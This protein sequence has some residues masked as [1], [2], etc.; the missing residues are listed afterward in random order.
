MTSP[1]RTGKER[2][3]MR[4]SRASRARTTAVLAAGVTL[5]ACADTREPA[6]LILTGGKIATVDES[7]SIAETIV[8]KDGR[9]LAVGGND[10]ADQYLANTTVDLEGRLVVPGFNDT[11][12]H[13]RGN[14]RRHIDLGGT[15][16]IQE[17]QS[18]VREKVAEIGEGE[19]ITGYGWSEDELAEGRRPLRDDLDEAAPNSPVILT[20]AGGH[21]GVANSLALSLAEVDELTPQPDGGVIERDA[22]GRLNGVIRERQGIVSR[23]VPDATP[24]E[25]RETQVQMLRDQLALGITS[26]IQAGESPAGFARWQ[27]IY[28]EFGTELPRAAVQIRWVGGDRLAEFGQTTGD[29]DDRLRVGAIKV[30]VDGGFTGPAA[31]TIEPYKGQSDYRGMLNLPEEELRSLVLEA[32]AL[33]WQLGF[34][35]IGDAAIEL[36]VDAFVDALERDP[37]EDHRHYLNHFTVP[38]PES[39]LDLMAAH[40]IAIAQQPNFTYTL[41]GRYVENLDGDRLAHNNPVRVPMEH[42]IFM[43]LGSDILPIDPRVGL[44]AAVTRKGM[45]GEVFGPSE[46][47]TIAEAIRGYTANGAWLTFEEDTK[48]T[49]EVGMLADMVVLSEDLL[50]INPE[51]ILDVEVDMTIVGGQLLYERNR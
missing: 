27:D 42:G 7:F 43:A 16:S 39:T 50:T 22:S 14:A 17:I 9:V 5:V 33:G 26:L 31:Y 15:E 38:P 4:S 28:N 18:L 2:K 51:R 41:E 21:S 48:G 13:I 19:W 34:H 12:T 49:L 20:R 25:L 40:G 11:H 8:V 30:L 44:Y 45:S 46:A 23:L 36:T 29:G 37:R 24:E 6:D 32:N 35:A 47:L 3:S 1:R 10:L